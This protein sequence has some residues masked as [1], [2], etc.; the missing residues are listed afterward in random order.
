MPILPDYL[1]H[2]DENAEIQL[3]NKVNLYQPKLRTSENIDQLQIQPTIVPQLSLSQSRGNHEK[4]TIDLN[5]TK[6][7]S[8]TNI[9]SKNILKIPKNLI[10][11]T[12]SMKN[13][14]GLGKNRKDKLIPSHNENEIIFSPSGRPLYKPKVK[15]YYSLLI[16]R[17]KRNLHDFQKY[18]SEFHNMMRPIDQKSSYSLQHK[19]I[20]N[21]KLN[22]RYQSGLTNKLNDTYKNANATKKW[23]D[24]FVIV[25]VRKSKINETIPPVNSKLN[26]TGADNEQTFGEVKLNN[27]VKDKDYFQ[28]ADLKSE[29]LTAKS[30]SSL[31]Q[32]RTVDL[33]NEGEMIGL[34][35][36]SRSLVQLFVNPLVGPLTLKVGYSMPLFIG[37]V[38][39][40]LSSISKYQNTLVN[41]VSFYHY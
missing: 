30:L 26:P 41:T 39:L 23:N 19:L 36:S 37:C 28:T 35:F 9:L 6:K 32:G 4:H 31:G 24:R 33:E 13:L 7:K 2:I 21:Q 1:T 3:F 5:S 29:Y 27:S 18:S 15:N 38:S 8:L 20:E 25:E 10:Q 11:P 40:L 12:H 34:L 14:D 16:K 22:S 17:K